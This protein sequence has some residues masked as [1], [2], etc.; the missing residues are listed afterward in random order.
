MVCVLRQRE[1]QDAG[2]KPGATTAFGCD[3]CFARRQECLRYLEEAS[4]TAQKQK[5]PD[6]SRG[7]N[8]YQDSV[9]QQQ[10]FVK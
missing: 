6:Q 7:S 4:R 10:P 2:L 5:R 3:F 8:F 9:L 1:K